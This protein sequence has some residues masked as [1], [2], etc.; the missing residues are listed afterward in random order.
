V[1]HQP[2][3]EAH[4]RA[5]GIRPV[6]LVP[7]ADGVIIKRARMELKVGGTGA[8]QL[9]L[10]L[11][12]RAAR[13]ESLDEIVASLPAAEESSARALLAQLEQHRL[14]VHAGEPGPEEPWETPLDLFHWSAGPAAVGAADKVTNARITVI[15][16]N[17]VSRTLLAGLGQ[18]GFG[19]I[20][21]V[22]YPF[23]CNLRMLDEAGELDARE[24]SDSLRAPV[25]YATWSA[26]ERS[27]VDCLI[28]T[29]D[30]GGLDLMR[31]W[32]EYCMQRG[33]PFLP[34]VLQ[35]LVGYLGPL[36]V[37]GRTACFECARVRQNAN[38]D[39]PTDVRAAEPLA[40]FGQG[41][42]AAYHPALPA[43][44]GNFA[45][46]EV[47]RFVGGWGSPRTLGTLV[48]I[49]LLAPE[50][51]S[52]PVLKLPRCRVCGDSSLCSTTAVFR[53]LLIPSTQ[54]P[55]G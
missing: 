3:T 42:T 44:L 6:Q 20:E 4:S 41:V 26:R 19:N 39:D 5:I 51:V 16:V 9:V 10:T 46:L 15:G 27:D 33:I 25:D 43:I 22:H 30:F 32:N 47:S 37:R 53:G 35:D 8:Y 55:H 49:D 54:E 12:D 1:Q 45:A 17:E 21:I 24:W 50:L 36:S 7:T 38:L 11:L 31:V 48:E 23:L 40:F 13:G 28:A 2:V 14:L 52:R 29:S 34:V 18:A